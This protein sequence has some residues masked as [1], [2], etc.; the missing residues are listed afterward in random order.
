MPI[1][2]PVKRPNTFLELLYNIAIPSI[3]LMKLST[4]EYLGTVPALIFALLF[5]LGYGLYDFIKNKSMNFIS[6]LGFF[7]TL[8]TGGIGL[9]ELDVEWLAIKEAAIPSVIGIVVLISGFW[10]KPLIAKILLNPLLFNLDLIYQTLASKNKTD[11]FKARIQWANHLLAS[12]FVFSATMNYLLAKW[13]VISPAGTVEF[14]EQLGEMTLLSY[15]VIAVPSMVMLIAIM[16]YVVKS[17][18]KL[19]DLTLEKIL[20]GEK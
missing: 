4:D 2:T 1:Q 10:G 13:I 19:T 9:F 17:T 11:Q 12:T 8:L 6:L 5:P 3:I 20:N 14:N 16:F 15:P 18:M 7:S